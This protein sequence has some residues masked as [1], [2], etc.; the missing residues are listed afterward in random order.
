MGRKES[1]QTNKTIL[2]I[3]K[4]FTEEIKQIVP[5]QTAPLG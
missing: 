5:D 4:S 3:N 2:V 1:I